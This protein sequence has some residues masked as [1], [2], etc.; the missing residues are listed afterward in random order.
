MARILGEKLKQ[1]P[2]IRVTQEVQSNGVFVIIP[3][4]I[5]ERIRASYFFYPWDEK[6]SEWRLMCSWDTEEEDI[7]NFIAL[8]KKE[9]T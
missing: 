4:D 1:I 5:A 8:L 3:N 2:G 7:E 9:L 6:R